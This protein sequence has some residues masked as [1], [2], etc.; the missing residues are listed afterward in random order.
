MPEG[1]P[2]RIGHLWG[3]ASLASL[4]GSFAVLIYIIWAGHFTFLETSNEAY[5][6]VVLSTALLALGIACLS[7]GA[8]YV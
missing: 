2:S 6:L 4:L 7:K 1:P 8:D 3:F 5:P